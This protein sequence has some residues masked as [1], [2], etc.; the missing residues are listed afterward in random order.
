[1]TFHSDPLIPSFSRS[2]AKTAE[3]IRKEETIM[4]QPTIL[5]QLVAVIR[6]RDKLLVLVEKLQ[7]QLVKAN[8]AV[9][10]LAASREENKALR[11]EVRTLKRERASIEAQLIAQSTPAEAKLKAPRKPRQS[12]KA[13]QPTIVDVVLPEPTPAELEEEY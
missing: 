7:Q 11:A 8:K 2:P 3:I 1:V 10:K 6:Q 9:E 4:A 12:R 13:A 5:S